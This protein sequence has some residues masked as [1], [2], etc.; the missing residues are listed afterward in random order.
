MTV[1]YFFK[2]AVAYAAS[3]G[4]ELTSEEE[5]KAL[6]EELVSTRRERDILKKPWPSS[7]EN[8]T[9]TKIR[10]HTGSQGIIPCRG[11]VPGA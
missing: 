4:K 2:G 3:G 5:I 10:G 1:D 9:V 11:G 8:L 6:K 7:R